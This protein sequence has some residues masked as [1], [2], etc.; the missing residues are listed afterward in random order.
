M[1]GHLQA[2]AE[3][4]EPRAPHDTVQILICPEEWGQST[5][6]GPGQRP[7]R[8]DDHSLPTPPEPQ[9]RFDPS[10]FYNIRG[11][12]LVVALLTYPQQWGWRPGRPHS[13][14]P[15]VLCRCT[16]SI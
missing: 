12:T 7:S 3:A 11:A 6:R 15:T 9:R 10:L 1:R 13:V 14:A 4:N 16:P 8:R 5:E 2:E